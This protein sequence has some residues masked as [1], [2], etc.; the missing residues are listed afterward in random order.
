MGALFTRAMTVLS[1]LCQCKLMATETL[2]EERM[3]ANSGRIYGDNVRGMHRQRK[4]GDSD[5]S[6]W[7]Q[8]DA[9]RRDVAAICWHVIMPAAVGESPLQSVPNTLPVAEGESQK[10]P[11]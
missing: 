11:C 10:E 4:E 5:K 3:R 9:H 8:W 1:V 7:L 2:R 6:R